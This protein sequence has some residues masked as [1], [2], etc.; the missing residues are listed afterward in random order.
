MIHRLLSH[1]LL[2]GHT[3]DTEVSL[4]IVMARCKT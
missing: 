3:G 4:R 2:P 1:D